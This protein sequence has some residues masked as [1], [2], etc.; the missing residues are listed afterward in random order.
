MAKKKAR[1]RKGANGKASVPPPDRA[2]DPPASG[3]EHE[4][5]AES[6]PAP[7]SAPGE[8]EA[9]PRESSAA[10]AAASSD[11]AEPKG[12]AWGEPIA[13]FEKRWTHYESRLI[14]FVLVWQLLALVAWVFLSGLSSPLAAG[15][16]AGMVF[17]AVA[18]AVAFGLGG[19]LATRQKT[20]NVRRAAAVGGLLFGIA[21][22]PLWR[23]AGVEYF[24]NVKGWLQEGS[25]LTLMGG[26]R[27]LATRLTLWLALL[28]ASLA[29]AAGKHIHIDV[30]F[31]FLPV[32]FRLP[33]AV[34]NFVSAAMMCFAATWGFIDHIAIESFGAR[35]EDS[36]RAKIGRVTH[37]IGQHAFLTRKQI[38]LDLRTLP[39]VVAGDRYDRWMSPAEWNAWVKDAG[40]ESYYSPEDVKTILVLEEPTEPPHP[41]FVIAPD[42]TTSRGALVHD[43]NLVFPFGLF[44][45]GLRFLLRALLAMSRHINLDPDAAHRDE[46]KELSH[47]APAEKGAA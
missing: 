18:G 47:E 2:S 28:G 32:R 39:H 12:A 14:T 19:W 3:E 26:L 29:T 45:I 21:I 25:T 5:A 16:S 43:L 22:A 8:A 30:I 23:S 44:V 11:A 7:L 42:G 9:E 34:V 38:G 36:A 10:A 15:N 31:R 35:A 1:S 20:L 37:H 4:A 33:A 24:D 40:F 46:I 27:G 17:R 13:R 6:E 41:P